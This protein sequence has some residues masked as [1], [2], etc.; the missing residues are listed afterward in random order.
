MDIDV[1]RFFYDEDHG[2][3]Y[4]S[5]ANLGEDA[6]NI[7]WKM[8]CKEA[9]HYNYL[10]TEDKRETFLKT[11]REWGAWE[12]ADI[13]KWTPTEVNALF[14]QLVAAAVRESGFNIHNWDWKAYDADESGNHE[15]CRADNR[16]YYTIS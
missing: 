10:D 9:G 14:L 7:T 12:E 11:V 3:F 13:A 1:T 2:Q 16:I 4:N 5:V 6:A 15:L 8:A